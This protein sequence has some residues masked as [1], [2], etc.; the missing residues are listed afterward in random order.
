MSKETID[1]LKNKEI[2]LNAMA[3]KRYLETNGL[4]EELLDDFCSLLTHVEKIGKLQTERLKSE[5]LVSPEN[6]PKVA[7]VLSKLARIRMEMASLTENL[8]ELGLDPKKFIKND[9]NLHLR[10]NELVDAVGELNEKLPE[11]SKI[12]EITPFLKGFL[13]N[14]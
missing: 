5:S 1:K 6:R 3:F 9:E 13:P 7:A 8:E 12:E 4:P 2:R 10:T 11:G 14:E